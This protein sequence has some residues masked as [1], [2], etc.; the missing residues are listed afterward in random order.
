M[1]KRLLSLLLCVLLVA[2]LLPSVALAAEDITGG[3]T[4]TSIEKIE[5]TLNA[6]RGNLELTLS[7][8]N[9]P[10]WISYIVF[11]KAYNDNDGEGWGATSF[12]SEA[13]MGTEGAKRYVAASGWQDNTIINGFKATIPV[14]L[15]DASYYG[16][17]QWILIRDS[18]NSGVT[19][20]W[21]FTTDA[22]GNIGFTKET[23]D[24]TFS[25]A[26]GADKVFNGSAQAP[27]AAKI[28]ASKAG[29]GA[30]TVHS[31]TTANSAAGSLGG[32]QTNVGTYY[33][34]V[35]AAEGDTY[36]A[37]TTPTLV[38]GTWKITPAARPDPTVT[39]TAATEDGFTLNVTNGAKYA[40]TTSNTA[41]AQGDSAYTGT[42]SGAN[43]VLNDKNSDT[44]Y[45][46]HA[47]VEAGDANHTASKTVTKSIKTNKA[48]AQDTTLALADGAAA[49]GTYGVDAF[50]GVKLTGNKDGQVVD[51]GKYTVTWTNAAGETVTKPTAVGVYTAT[52]K[53]NPGEDYN[54]PAAGVNFTVGKAD[55]TLSNKSGDNTVDLSAWNLDSIATG[56]VQYDEKLADIF[57]AVTVAGDPAVY[58]DAHNIVTLTFYEEVPEVPAVDCTCPDGTHDDTNP[59]CPKADAIPAHYEKITA[60]PAAGK[61]YYVDIAVAANT[62]DLTNYNSVA[63]TAGVPTAGTLAQF[64]K[65]TFAAAPSTSGGGVSN[66]FTVTYNAGA[67]GAL[68][69]GAKS[70]EQVK[71]NES[72]KNVPA[73]VANAG[74]A[75]IGWTADGKTLVNP[76]A[77]TITKNTTF[78]AVYG[79]HLNYMVGRSVMEFV[80]DGNL[81]RAEAAAILSR[82]TEGFEEDGTY[83]AA[84]YSDLVAGAWYVKYV[85]FAADKGIV[86]GRTDG[87]FD[88]DANITRAEFATMIANF[89]KIAPVDTAAVSTDVAGHWA[90]GYIAA[91]EQAKIVTGYEDGTFKP[92]NSITRA[93]AATMV[94]GAIGRVPMTGLDLSV[95]GYDNPF[96]DVNES[97]WFYGQVMEATVDHVTAHFHK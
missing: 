31:V 26:A 18:I 83:P 4:S 82:L 9:T 75:F 24:G 21:S 1:K 48:G 92:N 63:K 6:G 95:N 3:T 56:T 47:Y 58:K 91:L 32:K 44:T 8:A 42:G 29:L 54:A 97:Q 67:H 43:V 70:S 14:T 62:A 40:I 22:S 55:L 39:L 30:I 37:I 41:P 46:V 19:T 71:R 10:G 88:P 45:Y 85:N 78:T 93:E 25:F 49:T 52:A 72:P 57:G 33:A 61:T 86:N 27:D 34:W 66:N 28:T 16:K 35:T 68:A 73:V 80:P 11:D 74:Y 23:Y 65:V 81:T 13:L 87:T 53:I 12:P 60:A 5:I 50:P 64:T 77:Q 89:A 20:K 76:A 36:A 2:S 59:D 7:G 38:T 94:N 84:P 15:K 96:V 69:A 17:E 79:D 90:E 51:A